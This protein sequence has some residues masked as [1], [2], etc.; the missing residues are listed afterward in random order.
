[1]L[2]DQAS[3]RAR[4]AGRLHARAGAGGGRGR[5]GRAHPGGDARRPHRAGSTTRSRRPPRNCRTSRCGSP[6]SAGAS[7]IARGEHLQLIQPQL[8][9]ADELRHP[10]RLGLAQGLAQQLA[11]ALAVAVAAARDQ[12]LRVLAPHQRDDRPQAARRVDLQ[13]LPR[14]AARRRRTGPARRSAA[15]GSGA[16]SRGWRP[17]RPGRACRGAARAAGRAPGACSR[18]ADQRAGLAEQRDRGEPE[19][20][21]R[22]RGELVLASVAEL[23]HAR[24]RCSRR[25]GA[26]SAGSRARR[27]A[28]G[29]AGCSPRSRRRSP[30]ARPRGGAGSASGRRGSS[31]RRGR[32]RGGRARRPRAR[33]ARRRRRGPPSAPTRPPSR[34]R[35]GDRAAGAARRRASR[36]RGGRRARP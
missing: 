33:A 4:G 6:S 29:S 26:P 22:D 5:R 15:R 10:A 31:R 28:P 13:R 21:A 2:P 1:M 19:H 32:R 17:G 7:C 35:S 9:A 24:L 11:R 23:R 3:D 30:A 14:S 36:A 25:A 16:W 12:H 20:V 18:V 27:R 8:H 34:P